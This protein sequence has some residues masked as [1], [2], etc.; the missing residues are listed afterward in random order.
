MDV[1]IAQAKE[2]QEDI[3]RS[4]A[5]AR[6]IVREH[7]ETKLS[8]AEAVDFKAKAILLREEIDFNNRVVQILDYIKSIDDSLLAAEDA[9]AKGD[10]LASA[11]EWEGVQLRLEESSAHNAQKMIQD[12]LSELREVISGKLDHVLCSRIVFDDGGQTRSLN[13]VP[14]TAGKHRNHLSQRHSML[15]DCRFFNTKHGQMPRSSPKAWRL[16]SQRKVCVQK[17]EESHLPARPCRRTARTRVIDFR[18]RPPT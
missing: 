13:V 6:Q 2:L 4:R 18:Q 7:D 11:T 16:R 3:V 15:S 17:Y 8:T 10:L 14:D 9:L 1:W 12:R 5:T